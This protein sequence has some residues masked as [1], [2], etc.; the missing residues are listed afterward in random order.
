M[1]MVRR[2]AH[3]AAEQFGRHARVVDEVLN[4]TVTSQ[5]PQQPKDEEAAS[6]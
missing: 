5:N 2:Y 1:D 3:L 4:G 6:V